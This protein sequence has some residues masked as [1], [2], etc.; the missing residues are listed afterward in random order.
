[1]PH[2]QCHLYVDFLICRAESRLSWLAGW[3][4]YDVQWRIHDFDDKF[5]MLTKID[6]Y[7]VSKVRFSESTLGKRAEKWK[8]KDKKRVS[9]KVWQTRSSMVAGEPC[10]YGARFG[11]LFDFF[12]FF[13]HIS[14]WHFWTCLSCSKVVLKMCKMRSRISNF[15]GKSKTMSREAVVL[16]QKAKIGSNDVTI[17]WN[18]GWSFL[19]IKWDQPQALI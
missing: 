8:N 1:M 5:M 10:T 15:A 11:R 14:S 3:W 19:R 4:I 2:N 13:W 16:S 9:A 6:Q 7:H 18:L 12:F 17:I